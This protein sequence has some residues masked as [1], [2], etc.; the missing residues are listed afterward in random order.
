MRTVIFDLDGTLAD[1]S[2]DLIAAANAC[3]RGL[4]YGDVLDP[5]ADA[6]TAFRGGRAMLTLG[7]SRVKPGFGEAEVMEQYPILLDVYAE[8]IDTHT[9]LY[10]GAAEAV[11]ALR[12]DG[13][14]VGVCTNKPEDLAD[15]LLTRLGVRDLFGSMIGAK[16]VGVSKPDPKPYVA[17]VEEAGGVLAQSF[18]VGDTETDRATAKAAG[19]PSVL[20]TFGPDGDGVKRL[21]PEALL[22]HYNEL[23]RLTKELIG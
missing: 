1:T 12:R 15:R 3:F 8:H 7:F 9:R 20:V 11:E 2:A 22:T 19:V 18:L 23:S 16:T 4:G 5:V 6:H 14:A 10:E 21:E 17:A 13:Y